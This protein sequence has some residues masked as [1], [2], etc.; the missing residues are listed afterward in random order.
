MRG[1]ILSGI[2]T[3]HAVFPIFWLLPRPLQKKIMYFNHGPWFQCAPLAFLILCAQEHYKIAAG[4]DIPIFLAVLSRGID[5][6]VRE[7]GRLIV[8]LCAGAW[9]RGGIWFKGLRAVWSTGHFAGGSCAIGHFA[10]GPVDSVGELDEVECCWGRVERQCCAQR[11]TQPKLGKV[12]ITWMFGKCRLLKYS[13][14]T[15]VTRP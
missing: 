12:I 4:M 5:D 13:S 1:R 6:S 7:R 14:V 3:W 8:W 10:D 9:D 11:C 2:L 15:V